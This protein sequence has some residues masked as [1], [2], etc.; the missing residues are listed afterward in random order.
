M[1]EGE[2]RQPAR[3][4]LR[5]RLALLV[6]IHCSRGAPRPSQRGYRCADKRSS[7]GT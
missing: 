3:A 4:D 7:A 1:Q 2:L 5:C 6:T